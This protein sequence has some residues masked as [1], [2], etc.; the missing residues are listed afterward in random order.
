[1]YMCG[2]LWKVC[3]PYTTIQAQIHIHALRVRLRVPAACES[4]RFRSS[5]HKLRG[6]RRSLLCAGDVCYAFRDGR[7]K[8]AKSLSGPPQTSHLA[9]SECNL[10]PPIQ[11]STEI[12]PLAAPLRM[13]LSVFPHVYSSF[14]GWGFP[15]GGLHKSGVKPWDG[16]GTVRVVYILYHKL[17]RVG[18]V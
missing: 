6:S 14:C 12:F 3:T 4:R 8:E 5:L 10:V 7:A 13:P 11:G 15:P 1:M 18:A 9:V 2:K 17:L 16:R